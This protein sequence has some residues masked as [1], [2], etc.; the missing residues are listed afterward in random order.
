VK[1]SH[2]W[3]KIADQVEFRI[4]LPD[5]QIVSNSTKHRRSPLRSLMASRP[6]L[7]ATAPHWCPIDDDRRSPRIRQTMASATGPI[8]MQATMPNVTV[9]M[10]DGHA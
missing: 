9:T 3:T 1:A 10:V 7:Q 2:E 5:V 4:L 6:Q 8:A